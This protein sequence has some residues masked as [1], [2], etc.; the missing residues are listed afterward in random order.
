MQKLIS[1]YIFNLQ[2]NLKI[3][4]YNAKKIEYEKY[5]TERKKK[6]NKNVSCN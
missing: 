1:R 5:K 6:Q 4:S 2:I 3:F